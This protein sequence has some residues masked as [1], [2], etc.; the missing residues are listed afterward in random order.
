ML[1]ISYIID[2]RDLI[3]KLYFL[4]RAYFLWL[5]IIQFA[6]NH[7]QSLNNEILI[8]KTKLQFTRNKTLYADIDIPHIVLQIHWK[9]IKLVI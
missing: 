9:Q 3:K 1:L 7:I 4:T 8:K 2:L 6:R 5:L